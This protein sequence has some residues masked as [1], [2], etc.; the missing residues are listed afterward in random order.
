MDLL[1]SLK[2]N[3]L[4]D[5]PWNFSYGLLSFEQVKDY[6]TTLL[7][8]N[9]S[10]M[11]TVEKELLC[12]E[13][14]DKCL[15]NLMLKS[16]A[17][18]YITNLCDTWKLHDEVKFAAIEMFGKFHALLLSQIYETI[19]ERP[20]K[21]L[22]LYNQGQSNEDT[23]V[24]NSK[25]QITEKNNQWNQ[26]LEHVAKQMELRAVSCIVIANKLDEHKQG[27]VNLSFAAKYLSEK[28]FNYNIDALIKSEL[29]VLK[30]FQYNLGS[31]LLV[32]P[33]VGV[34]IDY[35]FHIDRTFSREDIYV[36][37]T[38]LLNCFYPRLFMMAEAFQQ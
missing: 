15:L 31:M 12:H 2:K 30:T 24:C 11:K 22:R 29:R 37:S 1:K 34:L 4:S 32:M 13:F 9:N 28:G 7:D 38:E 5:I 20:E 10:V 35:L 21:T 8:K 33:H 14:H 26:T 6:C 19:Y 23:I 25:E 17:A 27:P 16:Y 3:S 36:L 18:E